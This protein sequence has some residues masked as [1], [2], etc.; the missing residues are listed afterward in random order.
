MSL[1]LLQYDSIR[2]AWY[3]HQRL[4][5]LNQYFASDAD[6]IFFAR[7]AFEQHH[8]RSSINFAMHK[9]KSGALPAGAV[10]GNFKRQL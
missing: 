1:T 3:F 5:N 10:K 6:Y 2:P 9:F 4:R 7:S 8:L